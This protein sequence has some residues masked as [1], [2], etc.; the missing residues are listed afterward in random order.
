M[1]KLFFWIG[2]KWQMWRLNRK[3]AKRVT[4]GFKSNERTNMYMAAQ[5]KLNQATDNSNGG[6]TRE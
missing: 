4:E 5:M 3:L 2:Q 6:F 1:F